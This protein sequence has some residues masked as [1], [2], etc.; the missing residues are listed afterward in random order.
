MKHLGSWFGEGT[1]F[2]SGLFFLLDALQGSP[3][4]SVWP[5]GCLRSPRTFSL[6]GLA[7]PPEGNSNLKLIA[8]Q[9]EGGGSAQLA[10]GCE[11]HGELQAGCGAQEGEVKGC[12]AG[13]FEVCLKALLEAEVFE[14]C[15]A[16]YSCCR[17]SFEALQ[18]VDWESF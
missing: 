5:P 10:A 11:A 6:G 16:V 2:V 1:L 3:K 18:H 15:R 13:I 14:V 7:R 17:A 4:Q 12:R 8:V 9:A